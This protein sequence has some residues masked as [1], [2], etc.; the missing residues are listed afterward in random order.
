MIVVTGG[1]G[2]IGSILVRELNRRGRQDIIIV[3]RFGGDERWKNLYDLKFYDLLDADRFLA[4]MSSNQ[5][6][7]IE[8]IFH[9]GAESSTTVTDFAYLLQNNVAYSQTLFA[10]AA[11]N[12]ID[13]IYAS[14]AA[15]YGDGSR[16]Y[17][18]ATMP[19]KPLNGYGMSKYLFDNWALQQTV[20]PPIWAGLRFFNVYGPN[21]YH[22]EGM[23]SMVWQGFK[24][25]QEKKV[26]RLFKSHHPDYAD[27]E[28]KRD[29]IYVNDVVRGTLDLHAALDEDHCGIYNLG[30]GKARSFKDLALAVFAALD[31]K[32]DIEYIPTPDHIRPQYQY[33]TQAD[34]TK[35]L[36]IIPSFTFTSLEDGV[37]DYV[38]NY[39]L[40]L[41]GLNS[42]KK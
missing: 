38:Q 39:L 10:Y 23:S 2:F 30:T 13:F 9:L 6:P 32:P 22:K 12:K 15:T 40:Q 11:Q 34:M 29:F 3:E 16:G 1:A 41:P 21:E 31:Q 19:L 36:S 4:L 7:Q 26:I 17:Q 18:E 37:K 33:F 20:T 42:D 27:G 14:S 28:Q 24:Q 8:V 25:A 35:F 5:L